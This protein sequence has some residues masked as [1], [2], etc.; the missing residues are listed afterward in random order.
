MQTESRHIAVW[1]DRPATEV[2]DY[3]SD[4]LNVPKWAPGL[5]T[6]V[7]QVD[8]QLFADSPMGRITLTFAPRNEF[9]VLDHDVTLA[10]GETFHNPMRVIAYG[11]AC[12]VMFTLRKGPDVS[13]EDFARDAAA[14][15]ADL[16]QLKQLLEAS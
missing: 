3:A 7:E 2:Y 15:S 14:V 10:S 5:G 9:C 8:G 16:A 1:I 12:E 13:D 11:D 6:A 4:P